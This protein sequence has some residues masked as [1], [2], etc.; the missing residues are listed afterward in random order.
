M[1]DKNTPRPID[2]QAGLG[3][4]LTELIGLH[5]IQEDRAMKAGKDY[6]TAIR[7]EQLYKQGLEDEEYSK[8]WSDEFLRSFKDLSR[9]AYGPRPEGKVEDTEDFAIT[10]IAKSIT[11]K[12]EIKPTVKPVIPSKPS[13][14]LQ[15]SIPDWQKAFKITSTKDMTPEEELRTMM[16]PTLETDQ[17]DLNEQL[18]RINLNIPIIRNYGG[19][20][21]REFQ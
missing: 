19:V 9:Q 18:R 1:A 15:V 11:P 6:F 7:S 3:A 10:S 2:R 21:T 14:E 12:K 13:D 17:M 5:Q 20:I 16:S 4:G 8:R